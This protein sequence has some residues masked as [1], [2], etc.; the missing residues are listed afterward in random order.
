MRIMSDRFNVMVAAAAGLLSAC[1]G[2]GGGETA[3]VPGPGG[4][5]PQ[6]NVNIDNPTLV[7]A[8]NDEVSE[9]DTL[10]LVWSDEFNG[11]SLD[12]E[13]WFFEEGNGS[14][15]GIPGWGNNELQWY[16]EDSAELSDGL[17]V[18][19]AREESMG[20]KN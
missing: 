11:A 2:G 3:N 14:Q 7:V 20:G 4:V 9:G 18:I 12:P 8:L 10:T 15:Y 19:A 1:S 17:F 13:T 6:S 16:L 5:P